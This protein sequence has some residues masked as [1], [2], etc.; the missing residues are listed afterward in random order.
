LCA[1]RVCH[2]VFSVSIVALLLMRRRLAA[3]EDESGSWFETRKPS[4][5]EGWAAFFSGTRPYSQG[6]G[7][8]ISAAA[9]E[10][11]SVD[12]ELNLAART[13]HQR[14]HLERVRK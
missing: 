11:P 6:R 5:P 1:P 12:L 2:N 7:Y 13:H 4:A 8:F 9:R 10:R 14:R 3:S